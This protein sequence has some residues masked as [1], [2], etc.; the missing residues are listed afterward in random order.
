MEAANAELS[1]K[2]KEMQQRNEVMSLDYELELENYQSTLEFF[3]TNYYGDQLLLF[4]IYCAALND[5]CLIGI[6]PLSF[7][8]SR[9]KKD[10]D[11]PSKKPD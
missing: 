10:S 11:D 7:W 3:E 4:L 2:L 1:K 6:L 5:T 9:A 8:I